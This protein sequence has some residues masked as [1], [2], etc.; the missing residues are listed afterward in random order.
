MQLAELLNHFKIKDRFRQGITDN[1]SKNY[2]YIELLTTKLFLNAKEN[3]VLYASH[4][5]NLIAKQ[6]L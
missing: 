4:I 2:T 6:A 3:H 5:I 1:A